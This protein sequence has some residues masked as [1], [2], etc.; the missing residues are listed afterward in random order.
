[1]KLLDGPEILI[2]I[3]VVCGIALV[4]YNWMYPD[5]GSRK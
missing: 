5:A 3:G 2:V 1:M 4:I